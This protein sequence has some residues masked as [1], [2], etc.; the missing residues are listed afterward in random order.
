MGDHDYSNPFAP[1][2]FPGWTEP[3]KTERALADKA[4]SESRDA[5]AQ[6]AYRFA[7]L[8]MPE[9]IRSKARVWGMEAFCEVLWNNAFQA[10][11]R[12]ASRDMTQAAIDRLTAQLREVSP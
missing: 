12:E 7:N 9:D 1:V 3:T 10:G 8:L 5:E 6:L 11:F 2:A 4:K